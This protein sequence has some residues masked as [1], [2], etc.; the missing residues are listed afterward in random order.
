MSFRTRAMV[1][2]F[3]LERRKTSPR[4][5]VQGARPQ[6]ARP[7]GRTRD[8]GVA[9]ASL[10][11]SGIAK[12]SNSGGCPR[13]S[14]RASRFESPL[15]HQEVLAN[16][17][18]FRI[19]GNCR[20][21]NGFVLRNAVCTRDFAHVRALAAGNARQS[22]A[23]KFRFP[24]RRMLSGCL[25]IDSVQRFTL[26][27]H[28]THRRPLCLDR[29]QEIAPGVVER[30]GASD[31]RSAANAS[32]STPALTIAD[33]VSLARPPSRDKAPPTSP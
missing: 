17:G 30:L 19:W 6:G 22:L 12:A 33:S 14:P 7:Q 23:A 5:L 26:I 20:E 8:F 31:W 11:L 13:A 29:L 32:R 15:L 27:A 4:D 2:W 9:T 24:N 10:W 21:F 18:G 28:P 25:R 1:L 16:R 3:S